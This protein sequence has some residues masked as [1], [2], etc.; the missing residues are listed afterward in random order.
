MISFGSKVVSFDVVE[1]LE[2]AVETDLFA[3]VCGEKCLYQFSGDRIADYSSADAE[4]VH[5]V[6]DNSLRGRIGVVAHRCAH[7]SELVRGYCSADATAAQYDASICLARLDR[8][9]YGRGPIRIVVFGVVR[10]GAEIYNAV[11]GRFDSRDNRFAQVESSVISAYCY[12]H[13]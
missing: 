7:A 6:V 4:Y 9:G 1:F 11:S 8:L 5:V 3:H 12:S 13:R 10:M 2:S